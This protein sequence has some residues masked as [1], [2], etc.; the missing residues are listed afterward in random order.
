VNDTAPGDHHQQQIEL[1]ERLE[2]ARQPTPSEPCLLRRDAGLAV[3]APVVDIHDPVADRVIE[4]MQRQRRRGG[5]L[6]GDEV[7]WEVRKQLAGQ[8]AEEPLDLAASLR[9]SAG[10]VDQPDVQVDAH[11]LDVLADEVAAVIAIEDVRQAVHRP[12]SVGLAADRLS[13][14]QRR[15]HRRRRM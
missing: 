15:V 8:R 9:P 14:R 13:Q 7:T 2:R 1:L 11:L 10:A 6:A 5:W 3:L 4:L 12:S